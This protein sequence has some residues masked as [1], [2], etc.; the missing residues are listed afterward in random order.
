MNYLLALILITSLV[1][2]VGASTK[3][4]DITIPSIEE[5]VPSIEEIKDSLEP[6][7]SS[8]TTYTEDSE[9]GYT[10]EGI[11]I[12]RKPSEEEM[13][14]MANLFADTNFEF[15]D[16]TEILSKDVNNILDRLNNASPSL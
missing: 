15:E 6:Q 4:V 12:T 13:D 7:D 1:I 14:L 2:S 16:H 3:L 11:Q 10:S 9:E 5:L 8:F